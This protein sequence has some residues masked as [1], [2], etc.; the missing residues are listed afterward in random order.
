MSHQ[1]WDLLQNK[2]LFEAIDAQNAEYDE[3]MHLACFTALLEQLLENLTRPR[4]TRVAKTTEASRQNRLYRL[5]KDELIWMILQN[6][7]Q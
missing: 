5:S 6:Q 4:S 2:S 1:L 3:P 7:L